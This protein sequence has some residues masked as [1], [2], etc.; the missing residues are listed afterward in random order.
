MKLEA[1]PPNA[2]AALLKALK[3]AAHKHREQRRKDSG[4]SPYINHPI[5]VAE[6]L[7]SVG[8][9]TDVTTLQA[10]ILHDTIEDTQT[11]REELDMHFGCEIRQLVEEM[12]D[13]KNLDKTVRKL[14]QIEYAPNLSLSAKQ[15]K[16]SDKICNIRDVTYSPPAN[17][18]LQRRR[19]YL[20]WTERVVAGCRGCNEGLEKFYDRV[21][22]ECRRALGQED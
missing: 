9:V 18:P 6:I 20:D 5:E 11:T 15:I 19:E 7:A 10:A 3:F 13:D 12:T 16:I 22:R 2:M 21:L 17:W 4:A 8:S 1:T 14:L